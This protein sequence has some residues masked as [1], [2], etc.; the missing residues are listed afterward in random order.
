M[1]F[2]IPTPAQV[3]RPWR[4]WSSLSWRVIGFN[5]GL[6]AVPRLIEITLHQ[7][8]PPMRV[9][10]GIFLHSPFFQPPATSESTFCESITY[11]LS[12]GIL[13]A[14]LNIFLSVISMGMMVR[15]I[16]LHGKE[17]WSHSFNI[18]TH[19][20]NS[21]ISSSDVFQQLFFL[22]HISGLDCSGVLKFPEQS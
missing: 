1:S 10:T 4:N 18:R 16:P 5:Q 11:L 22:L 6:P 7:S 3:G 21:C 19:S 20:T 2:L 8:A 9:C 12:K 17:T 13:P 15:T 14:N